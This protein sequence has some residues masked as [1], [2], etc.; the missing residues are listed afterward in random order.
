M[1]VLGH[2]SVQRGLVGA[3]LIEGLADQDAQIHPRLRD[4]VNAGLCCGSCR[5]GVKV[6]ERV[7]R[8]GVGAWELQVARQGLTEPR[9]LCECRDSHAG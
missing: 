4:H 6:A 2:Q 7:A 5:S 8:F 1:I 9:A 3:R